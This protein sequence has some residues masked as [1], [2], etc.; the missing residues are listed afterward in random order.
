MDKY[1]I[2]WSQTFQILKKNESF[3]TFIT[4]T[5]VNEGMCITIVPGSNIVK[6]RNKYMCTVP[7][8]QQTHFNTESDWLANWNPF[9]D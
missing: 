7:T 5:V 4:S 1:T 9:L 6:L 8:K 2:F 3:R